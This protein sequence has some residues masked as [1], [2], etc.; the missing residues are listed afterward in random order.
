MPA[1]LRDSCCEDVAPVR[2]PAS[3]HPSAETS[4]PPASRTN[5]VVPRDA[6]QDLAPASFER[7]AALPVWL[8]R[9]GSGSHGDSAPDR[10][11]HTLHLGVARSGSISPRPI[12]APSQQR[13]A[14]LLMPSKPH[15]RSPVRLRLAESAVV[16]GRRSR[17]VQT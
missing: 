3:C 12:P 1:H 6:G 15:L 8:T 17:P 9:R 14:V 16:P 13:K 5:P 7:L 2:L 11:R 10:K 4:P